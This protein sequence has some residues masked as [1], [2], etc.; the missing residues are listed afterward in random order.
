MGKMKEIAIEKM[1]ELLELE[2]DNQQ[3]R[4]ALA[5]CLIQMQGM[6][7]DCKN[8]PDDGCQ[9]CYEYWRLS[10]LAGL[11]KKENENGTA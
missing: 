7:H 3:L 8:A 6:D 2:F 4:T 9:W 10:N 1:N 11:N 5:W